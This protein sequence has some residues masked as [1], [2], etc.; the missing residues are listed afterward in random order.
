MQVGR[1]RSDMKT[2]APIYAASA[3]EV[4]L[5]SAHARKKD[6]GGSR[7]V[8]WRAPCAHDLTVTPHFRSS[9]GTTHFIRLSSPQ[10]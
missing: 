9:E 8:G 5:R 7:S 6:F 3:A 2:G 1:P 4:A 10:N